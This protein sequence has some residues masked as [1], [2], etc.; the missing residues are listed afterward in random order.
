MR[1]S[2]VIKSL[3]RGD[4]GPLIEFHRRIFGTIEMM[5]DE[6]DDTGGAGDKGDSDD[7]EDDD[8]GGD[9]DPDD[10][11]KGEKRDP[12]IKQLS[13]E[14]MRRRQEA[15]ALKKQNDELVAKVKSFEDADKGD[16][17]KAQGTITEL[18]TERDKLREQNSELV[19]RNA[20]LMDNKHE[21]ANPR[22]ALKLADLSEVEID[23]DGTVTGL[24][25][26]LN[27]LA[28]SDPYLLKS[29]SEDDDEDDKGPP[30]ATGQPPSKKSK[31]N[32]DREKLLSKYPAL[33]R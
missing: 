14:A 27:A 28:K 20:F 31:G 25:E 2:L 10:K 11:G 3:Q 9:D 12:R 1:P 5:A 24:A 6:D 32:P 16:L 21:W 23:D 19:I 7:D 22:A 15:K 18:T 17:E 8:T 26:A 29:K 13:D 4:A 30:S 33:N